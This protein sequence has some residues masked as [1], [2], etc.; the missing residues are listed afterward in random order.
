MARLAPPRLVVLLAAFA[1][2]APTGAGAQARV[3]VPAALAADAAARPVRVI[4]RVAAA[5]AAITRDTPAAA[6]A[7][8]RARIAAAEDAVLSRLT[9]HHVVSVRRFSYVAGFGAEVDRAALDAL[10]RTPGVRDITPD[11]PMRPAQVRPT[12]ASPQVVQSVPLIQAPRLWDQGFD[13]TGWTVAVLDSGVDPAHPFLLPR[14]VS[15]ACYSSTVPS[16]GASSLC[17]G[18]A[19]QS[20]AAGSGWNCTEELDDLYDDC[21]HGTHVAG[22]AVG[23]DQ[24]GGVRGVAPGATV[25]SIQVFSHFE[26]AELC[27]PET[28]CLLAY[29]SDQIRGL[30][31][32]LEVAASGTLSVAAANI[33]I[34]GETYASA[35]DLDYA[36]FK[37][38]V[39]RLRAVGV[40]T[41]VAA[42]N[43]GQPNALSAP[44][45]VSSVV[46]VGSTTKDD[47]LSYFSNR[48]AQLSLMA[49]GAYVV[50][51][52]VGGA[53]A[54]Y[55]GTSMASPHVAGAWALLK[56]AQPGAT[57]ASIL[58]ALRAT[59]APIADS[60]TGR[61]YRR[62]GV[63]DASVAL[64]TAPAGALPGTP[65]GLEAA[66]SGTTVTLT[67]TAP[68]GGAPVT[69]YELVAGR[70]PGADDV[71]R[72]ALGATPS[73]TAQVAA[74]TYYVRVAARNS[75][76]TGSPS[77]EVL[78][79]VGDRG[80]EPPPHAPGAPAGLT[81][82]VN[83]ST[84]TLSW[85]APSSD[86]PVTG[87]L[88]EAGSGP[89]LADIARMSVGPTTSIEITRVPAGSYVVRVRAMNGGALGAA[90]NE[91]VLVVP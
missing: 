87:Y 45:C 80:P 61:T 71:G 58:N 67:W 73:V 2:C 5:P 64:G 89:G 27:A 20:T 77:D 8:E 75:S 21:H 40:A 54:T 13:G 59:G 32:V 31:R 69:G 9:G 37:D 10:A 66:V 83:G 44:A 79:T 39:D 84:V 1:L 24:A 25:M 18:A 70:T 85:A 50:S 43:Q 52:I 12:P 36:A 11:L 38:V 90:S 7:A 6:Q 15:E 33:S 53:Y 28:S 47:A 82:E 23:N 48:S 63:A 16:Q 49:P 72:F 86:V 29:T 65:T 4:V 57:V 88:L 26:N 81:A 46:S 78:F 19:D 60:D 35:C 68:A 91:I 51:S 74:G 14:L 22:I 34:G 56:D 55:S 42:G 41:V 30:E 17:P 62:I 76:G 3:A